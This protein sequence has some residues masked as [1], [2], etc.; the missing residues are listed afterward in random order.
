MIRKTPEGASIAEPQQGARLFAP[1]AERNRAAIAELIGQIA[2]ESGKALEIASGTGQHVIAFAQA[3]PDMIWQPTDVAEDRLASIDAHAKES[4]GTIAPAQYLDATKPGWGAQ[5]APL[6]FVFLANLLHLISSVEAKILLAETALALA[7]GG[8]FL[9]YGPF[10]R[11]GQLTSPGDQS[12][13]E[14]LVRQDPEIGYKDVTDMI[15][16]AADSKMAHVK[17]HAMPAN[18]LALEFVKSK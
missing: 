15:A 1:A 10:M 16:W 2:P 7:P 18:N 13:H 3:R 4:A 6:S 14:S 8:K 17:T 11:D 5:A 12:F 9:V